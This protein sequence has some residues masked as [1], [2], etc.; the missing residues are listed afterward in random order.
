MPGIRREVRG[1]MRRLPRGGSRAPRPGPGTHGSSSRTRAWTTPTLIELR[2]RFAPRTAAASTSGPPSSQSRTSC[3]ASS[4]RRWP[5]A[6]GRRG[7]H[8]PPLRERPVQRACAAARSSSLRGSRADLERFLRAPQPRR[9][10]GHAEWLAAL[11]ALDLADAA[12]RDRMP[13]ATRSDPDLAAA[14]STCRSPSAAATATRAG[15]GTA[16]PSAS[17]DDRGD[18]QSRLRGQLAR[19]LPELGG[20]GAEL[21]R[22][23]RADHRRLP[24]R[25]HR[26]R[27]QP[28]PDHRATASTGRCADPAR[29]VEPHRLLGR[30]PDHLPAPA[31]REPGAL[32]A[33]RPRGR[34]DRASTC[35]I[36]GRALPDRRLREPL[37]D[38]P[39]DTIAFDKAMHR[40]ARGARPA[41]WA[42]TASCSP[43]SRAR[44]GSSSLCREAARPAAGKLYEPRPRRRHLAQH[45]APRVERRQQRPRRLGPVRGDRGARPPIPRP[46]ASGSFRGA[47]ER[48]DLRPGR[49]RFWIGVTPDPT[50]RR[51][52]SST[53]SIEAPGPA[54][55]RASRRGAPNGRLRR[56]PGGD[57]LRATAA[58]V[59]GALPRRARGRGPHDP[60][61]P[62]RR[63]PVPRLQ[64]AASG[65]PA[66]PRVTHL[67]PML[68]GQV[69]VLG[70]GTPRRRRGG[71]GPERA[72]RERHVPR[73]PADATCSTRT[74]CLPPFLAPQHVRR[75]AARSTIRG[76]FIR[77]SHGDWHF[78][79]DLRNGLELAARLDAMKVDGEV[80][81]ASLELWRDAVPAT[82]SSPA[83]AARSSCSRAWAASTGTW[84]PSCC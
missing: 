37:L 1:E 36:R 23:P 46:A 76:V 83:A 62:P 3:G 82:A 52:R 31:A 32:A 15:P 14:A 38:D 13:P 45:A 26:R 35:A 51:P 64:R 66:G 25:L 84:S 42:P 17:Q 24:Q 77:D 74:G 6:D 80:R 65:V 48:A 49:G 43:T 57:P 16:S 28:L 60:G 22:L 68:E 29:P 9:L 21:P 5:P 67:G 63:R 18:A 59:L 58:S 33:R 41:T 8:R 34:L 69:A 73:R 39:R 78:Q 11:P 7:R 54:G 44:S 79:A 72:A 47:G 70:C 75:A 27:L 30:P 20:A 12:R 40:D 53:T 4:P 10:Q 61:Q 56:R 81:A 19:H 71:R 55:G 2:D 50:A